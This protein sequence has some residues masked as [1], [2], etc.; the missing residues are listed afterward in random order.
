MTQ[1]S[2][3]V[4]KSTSQQVNGSTSLREGGGGA[5]EIS[6]FRIGGVLEWCSCWEKNCGSGGAFVSLWI[7]WRNVRSA[8]LH[9][10]NGGELITLKFI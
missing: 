9:Q 2:Q 10:R 5:F 1:K 6:K 7:N 4:N 8:V 3:Q